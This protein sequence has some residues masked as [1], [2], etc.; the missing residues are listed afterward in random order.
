M[1]KFL[2]LFI[3]SSSSIF[4]SMLIGIPW[5]F[6]KTSRSNGICLSSL[7]RVV[8][9]ETTQMLWREKLR[10][11]AWHHFLLGYVSK[12]DTSDLFTKPWNLK[13]ERTSETVPGTL[14]SWLMG[15]FRKSTRQTGK[16]WVRRGQR[17]R[18]RKVADTN[19]LVKHFSNFHRD[20][21]W[22][23][24]FSNMASDTLFSK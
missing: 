15:T 1:V 20:L 18:Y 14:H 6:S 17:Q 3:S 13:L 2:T 16:P 7:P 12:N 4:I 22:K 24:M 8:C 19:E 23:R 21:H 5:K 9:S 10:T 11:K